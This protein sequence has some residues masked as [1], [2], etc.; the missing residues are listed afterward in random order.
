V[1]INIAHNPG[2]NIAALFANQAPIPPYPTDLASAPNDFTLGVFF[3]FAGYNIP[4]A[5]AI[6]ASGNIW[7]ANN[8][9]SVSRF[10][11]L[12]AV[13]SGTGRYTG[14]GLS[15]PLA[16]IAIDSQ[17]NAWVANNGNSSLSLLSGSNGA[18][19]SGPGGITGGGIL[20]PLSIAIDGL[21]DVWTAN[22][23]NSVSELNSSGVAISGSGGYTGG[24]L[25]YPL[26]IAIDG[27]GDAWTTND[28][29]GSVSKSALRAWP[30]QGPMVTPG[31]V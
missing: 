22:N 7:I 27:S 16:A 20:T 26:S 11:G 28:Y 6:D 29:T 2:S 12:G 24:G 21:G 10:T 9:G 1:A 13:V 30:F 25:S 3:T 19:L 8:N 17:G 5:M 23:N 31:A 15:A 14:G 18:A 4:N